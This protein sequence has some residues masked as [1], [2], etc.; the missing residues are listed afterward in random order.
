M[1]SCV[2]IVHSAELEL[3]TEPECHLGLGALLGA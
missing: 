2:R 3:V 1:S